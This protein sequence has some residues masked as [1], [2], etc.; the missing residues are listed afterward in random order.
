MTR[1]SIVRAATA[2]VARTPT[3]GPTPRDRSGRA[4]AA[5][6]WCGMAT[7]VLGAAFAGFHQIMTTHT[8]Y[9]D[10]GYVMQSL[11][12]VLAGDALYDR[13]FTQYGPVPM[14]AALLF[15]RVTGL[16]VSHDVT[17]IV[18]LASWLVVS[19]LGG[20][21]AARLTRSRWMA[22]VGFVI[23]FLHME[24][25][26]LEPGHPQN[27]CA[28]GLVAAVLL[29]SRREGEPPSRG[30]LAALGLVVGAVLMTKVNV[31]VFLVASVCLVMLLRGPRT[32]IARYALAGVSAAVVLLPFVLVRAHLR[33][34]G[35]VL[36]PVAV[37][38]SAAGIVVVM[39]DR[40]H[41]V[42][43]LGDVA[44]FGA[45]VGAASVLSV[46]GMCATGSSLRGVWLGMTAVHRDFVKH[47]ATPAP[48]VA[49]VL[50]WSV[51][52]LVAAGSARRSWARALARGAMLGAL[53]IACVRYVTETFQ[54]LA[55]GLVDRGASG[56]LV[57]FAAPM[58][59][60]V[61]C[62]DDPDAADDGRL[63]LATIG[64]LQPLGAYPTPGSQ[65]AVGSL[66]VVVG[67]VV[68]AHDA[69]RAAVRAPVRRALAVASAAGL[70]AIVLVRAV[71]FQHRSRSLVALRLPG[72]AYLRMERRQAARYRWLARTLRERTDTFVFAEHALD[73]FYFWTEKQPPTALNP[74]YWP[75]MLSSEDEV[76]IVRALRSR[77]RVGVVH[78]PFAMA[79]PDSPLR[80]YI[81]A[82]FAP[83]VTDGYFH[84]WLPRPPPD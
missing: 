7:A 68:A 8:L 22:L 63:A 11:A 16:P 12:S 55:L 66:L 23:V 49:A 72:S 21:V 46:A 14:L 40:R 62:P 83:A 84:V 47:F 44:A 15:H 35:G 39:R 57:G 6:F 48:L 77:R 61:L 58:L 17:R 76:R 24:R 34:P 1:A 28:L 31:G 59:W 10:E 50:P 36:L 51:V 71:E 9:D 79:L 38:S 41:P 18:T 69:L 52:A 43:A 29:S 2:I 73:S 81:D 32:P 56:L 60:V 33:A 5:A 25:L 42:L 20:L 65:M 27:V 75:F 82:E 78:A 54:P 80:A 30:A 4:A 70:L 26:C 45:A 13:T 64:A 19:M 53:A 3:R 37:G 74:T 67:C